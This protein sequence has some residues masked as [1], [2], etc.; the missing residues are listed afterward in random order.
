MRILIVEDEAKLQAILERG[1]RGEGFAVDAAASA[2]SGLDFIKSFHYDLVVLDLLLPDGSGVTL[3]KHLRDRNKT[4][5]VLILT[6]RSDIESKTLTFQAGAD[7]YLTKPFSMAELSLRVKALLRRGSVAQVD[8]IRI[9]DLEMNR[10][11]RQVK[12]AGKRLELSPKEY[13]LLEYL[14]LHAGRTLSRSMIVERVWDQSFEGFTNIVDV[15]VGHLRRKVD[16]G[17]SVKLIR[18]V[19][20]IGYCIQ[21]CEA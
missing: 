2:Q 3:L 20:G 17:Y 16:E 7:D 18:T 14:M 12:R 6:A 4:L 13:S 9:D 11:T 10:I 21:S 5:P 1:L 8:E 19:R 15:Y